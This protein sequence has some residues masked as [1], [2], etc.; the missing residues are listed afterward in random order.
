VGRNSWYIRVIGC[1]SALAP[2]FRCGVALA[3]LG[4][5]V[6]LSVPADA[7]GPFDGVYTGTQATTLTNNSAECSKLDLSHTSITVTDSKF[8]RSWGGPIE[9]AVSPDGTFDTISRTK[10]GAGAVR[11]VEVKGRISA[12]GLEA[13]IGGRYCAVHLSLK[14]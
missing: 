5:G 7:A 14:K 8:T 6:T 9:V 3:C 2:R 10:F 4:V 1:A 11:T 12:G 13:D